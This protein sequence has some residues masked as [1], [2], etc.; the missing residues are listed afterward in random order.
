[1]NTVRSAVY[2]T[3][4]H[5][6]SLQLRSRHGYGRAKGKTDLEGAFDEFFLMGSASPPGFQFERV[7][8]DNVDF[9]YGPDIV[10][11]TSDNED[12]CLDN[13][14]LSLLYDN[15]DFEGDSFDRNFYKSYQARILFEE[16]L[17]ARD[18]DVAC[19]TLRHS[20]AL[21]SMKANLY[22]LTHQ[23]RMPFILGIHRDIVEELSPIAK[24]MIN[25][26]FEQDDRYV[27]TEQLHLYHQ[28]TRWR[29]MDSNL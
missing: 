5:R 9:F 17:T 26:G 6:L 4:G 21:I 1:M 20:A 25:S 16:S 10:V 15:L 18:I 24:L 3:I 14:V 12:G 22:S 19:A 7:A 23:Q 27:E 8:T 2:A 28:N 29:G 11:G 13:P